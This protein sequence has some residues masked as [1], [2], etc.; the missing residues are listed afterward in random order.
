MWSCNAI[1]YMCTIGML[2]FCRVLGAKVFSRP[3]VTKG[4]VETWKDSF[5][6]VYKSGQQ[7]VRVAV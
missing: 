5:Y 6:R 7:S 4:D 2:D 1:W 3:L